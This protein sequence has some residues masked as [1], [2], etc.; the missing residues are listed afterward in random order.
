MDDLNGTGAPRKQPAGS[1]GSM[2]VVKVPLVS[3]LRD[4]AFLGPIRAH[5][6]KVHQLK[7]HAYQLA[8]Y[9]LLR[10]MPWANFDA[11][12]YVDKTFFYEAFMCLTARVTKTT[13]KPNKSTAEKRKLV[14]KHIKAYMAL[15]KIEPVPFLY[16]GQSANYEAERMYTAYCNNVSLHLGDY[17][18]A[19][20]NRLLMTKCRS[21]Q[22]R[23][24]MK[25]RHC[26]PAEIREAV[27]QQVTLPAKQ[28][29]QAVFRCQFR[30]G[31]LDV[32][33]RQRLQPLAA[34][35]AAYPAA[36]E[37]V[38]DD[39]E[40]D[41]QKHPERHFCAFYELAKLFQSVDGRA[42]PCNGGH[43]MPG[44]RGQMAPADDGQQAPTK[45][46]EGAKGKRGRVFQ[47]FP[48]RTSWVPAHTHI[49]IPILCT[50]IL[51]CARPGNKSSDENK[52]SDE[53][54][55]SAAREWVV[56]TWGRVV[57]LNNRAFKPAS[58]A[59]PE[60]R[61]HFWGA[62]DMDGMSLSIIKKT[63]KEKLRHRG[64]QKLAEGQVAKPKQRQRTQRK[65]KAGSSKVPKQLPDIPYVHQVPHQ[66]LLETTKKALLLDPGRGDILHGIFQSSDPN[67][68]RNGERFR[69]T[70]RQEVVQRRMPRFKQIREKVK[71]QFQDG[72][73]QEVEDRL[74]Q[75]SRHTL[76]K[77]AFNK[78]I[79]ARSKE[80]QL[81]SNFYA[82]TE[83]VH[84]KSHHQ[85]HAKRAQYLAD[86]AAGVPLSKCQ[87]RKARQ[88]LSHELMNYP[89]HQK[90]RLSAYLN[91]QRFDA[92]LVSA[93]AV[94]ASDM[95]ATCSVLAAAAGALA[96][97]ASDVDAAC[98]ALA[99]AAGALAVA[100]GAQPVAKR[101][102]R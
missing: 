15:A 80:W 84:A 14:K 95:D 74:A 59:A 88:Y 81:L 13:K 62:V 66:Q 102:R 90:Q 37:F 76:D 4:T 94:M 34:V 86:E 70:H 48:L 29:K 71:C 67:D 23:K 87:Q 11:A 27:W 93:P 53:D 79:A 91:K 36:Y 40:A 17:L 45:H 30:L 65:R 58:N 1:V 7:T 18:R 38:D 52:P 3:V 10:E 73:V 6:E 8:R 55:L 35:F 51:G 39:I 101:W 89:L 56:E 42:A 43:V 96:E 64:R 46:V 44:K 2:E 57:H 25:A 33:T 83:T 47:A 98:S 49:D 75:F 20:V 60:L 19:A 12:K 78:Y 77:T 5:V 21:N 69:L 16:G 9:I 85:W 99:A 28:A 24:D 68:P 31:Q 26:Q 92:Y 61:R 41:S 50:Q 63:D 82:S 32:G 22:L 72:A 54:R 97:R 100:A